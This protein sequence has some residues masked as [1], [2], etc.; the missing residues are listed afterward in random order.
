MRRSAR[1]STLSR[2][3]AVT[4]DNSTA[5]TTRSRR[6]AEEPS[7]PLT[8]IG[9]TVDIWYDLWSTKRLNE[10]I[11]QRTG[12][13]PGP[14]ER[15]CYVRRL[16]ELD[17]EWTFHR[18]W[19]LPKE[20]RF[21]IYAKCLELQPSK[22]SGLLTCYPNILQTSSGI[23]KVAQPMLYTT[24]TFEL[25]I[26]T[27]EFSKLD[28]PVETLEDA[29]MEDIDELWPEMFSKITSITLVLRLVQGVIK[30]DDDDEATEHE[31]EAV[32]RD[33][34]KD[35]ETEEDDG[36]DDEANS[37]DHDEADADADE[38]GVEEEEEPRIEDAIAGDEDE[39]DVA[40]DSYQQLNHILY[41]LM[42]LPMLKNLHI[43]VKK[44]PEHV[45]D[46]LLESIL[47]PV[48]QLAHSTGARLTF[49]CVPV[50]VT[51]SLEDSRALTRKTSSHHTL[52][53]KLQDEVIPASGFYD[54]VA[55]SE[56]ANGIVRLLANII[57]EAEDCSN[58]LD[59]YFDSAHYDRCNTA[60]TALRSC[61]AST[62]FRDF[63]AKI[64]DGWTTAKTSS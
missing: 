10:A 60:L 1:I 53:C 44:C 4:P 24:N 8:P 46:E 55:A 64:L 5:T 30:Q 52:L 54:R 23:H 34:D 39:E 2:E 13:D 19:E 22:T 15:P 11:T 63:E 48:T 50:K 25:K 35:F 14:L 29:P 51:T 16:V 57:H 38:I 58:T 45:S 28:H 7:E 31:Q 21:A 37:S 56:R 18:F 36:D 17:Q 40:P 43:V 42:A 20:L 49:E 12:K 32:D 41:S 3:R 26:N 9:R 27:I 59:V 6:R 61:L 33:P 47:H 62:A